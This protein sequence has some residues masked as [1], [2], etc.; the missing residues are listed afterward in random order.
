MPAT[1]AGMTAEF[2]ATGTMLQDVP[3]ALLRHAPGECARLRTQQR[4]A[5]RMTFSDFAVLS[6]AGLLAVVNTSRSSY[7]KISKN[8]KTSKETPHEREK[9]KTSTSSRL[10]MACFLA[11]WLPSSTSRSLGCLEYYVFAT[12]IGVYHVVNGLVL[13]C[14]ISRYLS[15]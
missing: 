4:P 6:R 2:V 3:S 11:R 9:K 5:S 15:V 7:G 10:E 12:L 13:V 1:S 8:D 14:I